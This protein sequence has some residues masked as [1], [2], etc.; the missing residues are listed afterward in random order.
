MF[1]AVEEET[2]FYLPLTSDFVVSLYF[3][4]TMGSLPPNQIRRIAIIGAGP[5]GVA[6][7]K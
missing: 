4:P 2:P 5:G 3:A 6:A 7:A 1:C